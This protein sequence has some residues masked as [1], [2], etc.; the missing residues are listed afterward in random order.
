MNLMKFCPALVLVASL[1]VPMLGCRQKV[2]ATTEMEKAAVIMEEPK[3]SPA[4]PAPAATA[5]KVAAPAQEM[6]SAL[7]S[8]K[9]GDLQDAVTRLQR[10]RATPVMTPQQRIAVNDAIAAVMT[11]IS[12]LAAKGD[13]RALQA[14]QQYER[15][16]N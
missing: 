2:D 15:M 4:R 12:A 14:V 11:E 6:K 1:I 9:N 10:L 13:P 8:Y 16:Q 7:D 3:P 5:A